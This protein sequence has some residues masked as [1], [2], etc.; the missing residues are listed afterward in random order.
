MKTKDGLWK[1]S[2]S[3]L[4]TYEECRACFWVENRIGK[5]PM[6]PLRLNEAMDE[7]LK[8]RYDEY[9]KEGIMPPEVAHLSLQGI[10]LFSDQK[11]LDI[12]RNNKGA[13][14]LINQKDGYVLEG[15]LDEV[16]VNKKGE[17]APADY[18][19]SGDEPKIDKY[20]YYRL[21]LH[22]YALLLGEVGYKP[23]ETGYLLHYFTKDR[24]DSTLF[25]EFNFHIDEVPLK[26][27]AFQKTLQDMVRL[28]N[29]P[30]PNSHPLC[31]KCLWQEKRKFVLENS[32]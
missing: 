13:L 11:L 22:G 2:P 18:K 21:Q 19:S 17:Y 12:W 20:K 30:L 3:G 10:S 9:R 31:N 26:L 27:A 6:L 4:Y 23:G 5:P 14:Q 16:F 1:L 24:K 28:L 25:M 15:R 32:V 8:R 7:K 29:G